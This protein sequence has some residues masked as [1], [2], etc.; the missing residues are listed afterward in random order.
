MGS[1]VTLTKEQQRSLLK[2]WKVQESCDHPRG[3]SYLEFRRRAFPEGFG[4]DAVMIHSRGM[5]IGIEKDGYA[6]T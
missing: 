1:T 6:H 2:L 4:G 3:E 5:Y